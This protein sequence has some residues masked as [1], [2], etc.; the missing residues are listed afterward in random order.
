VIFVAITIASLTV[1]A[2]Q[3][4]IEV[5][6]GQQ[7]TD[8][9]SFVGT[10]ADTEELWIGTNG[11]EVYRSFDKGITWEMVFEP[12]SL[13]NLIDLKLKQLRNPS[14]QLDLLRDVNTALPVRDRTSI[15]KRSLDLGRQLRGRY[16]RPSAQILADIVDN[17]VRDTGTVNQIIKCFDYIYINA[18]NGIFRAPPGEP[19]RFDQLSTGQDTGGGH[20]TWLSCDSKRPGHMIG[21]TFNSQVLETFDFGDAWA[22]YT[23]PFA[24]EHRLSTAGFSDGRLVILAN[25][26]LYRER[27]DQRGYDY[28]CEYQTDSVEAA[29]AWAWRT[30]GPAYGVTSDGIIL[31]D[32]GKTTRLTYEGFARKPIAWVQI[33]GE[34]NEHIMVSTVDDVFLSHDSG[35]TWKLVFSRPTQR[36][37]D[38]VL[39]NDLSTMQDAIVWSGN[40]IY[41][42]ADR[43]R[44]A[45]ETPV[46]L[47][48]I[49]NRAPMW[50]VI[51]IGLRQY[52]VDGSQIAARRNDARY[53][54]L[55]PAITAQVSYA[56]KN[57]LNFTNN[58]LNPG[59]T[60][61]ANLFDKT[62][63][64]F[65]NQTIWTVTATWQLPDLLRSASSTDRSWADVERL[66]RRMMYRIEDAYTRW[67]MSALQLRRSGLSVQQRTF[68]EVQRNE[69]AAYLNY[70]TGG[71][72][73]VFGGKEAL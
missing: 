25:N 36:S 5:T 61:V 2:E 22:P 72:F 16:R 48:E 44:D 46:E 17:E 10:L 33:E 21:K 45:T 29:P 4:W 3:D 18:S 60:D 40:V 53:Q 58:L 13:D 6:P 51:E 23:N 19:L 12:K 7:V 55:L 56:D 24:F 38:L 41:R 65:P 15:A 67:A 20:I 30:Q 9:I 57:I 69:M 8:D 52:E 73:D 37:I 68:L 71:Q 27:E 34:H 63:T 64:S 66:R 54:G 31:C 26:R 43:T 28:I 50:E 47:Q 70:V 49:L 35:H 1:A 14:L 32:K 62:L 11:G 39:V 59:N 42:K